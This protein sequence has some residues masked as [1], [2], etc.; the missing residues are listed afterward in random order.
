MSSNSVIA[1][2]TIFLYFRMLFVMLVTIYISRVLLNTL[3]VSDYGVYNVVAGFISLFGFLNS[4]LTASVQR[5]YNYELGKSNN[6]GVSSVYTI[7]LLSSVIISILLVIVLESFGLWYIKNIMVIPEGRLQAAVMTFHA[8]VI[9]MV[10]IVMQI[11]YVGAVLAYEKMD[12]YAIVSI[13]DVVL[14]LGVVVS[15][16]YFSCDKLILYAFSCALISVIIFFV[17][18]I[19]SKSRFSAISLQKSINKDTLSQLLSFSGWN[20]FGT[21]AFIINGQGTNLLLNFFFG[22]VVNAARA[23]SLQVSSAV[24]NFTQSI[25]MAFRPQVVESYAKGDY[26]RVSRLFYFQSKLGLLLTN[27]MIVPIILEIELILKI[28]LGPTV[29]EYTAVFTVLTLL[30]QYISVINPSIVQVAFATGYIKNFQ[31]ATSIVNI[32]LIPIAGI[33]LMLNCDPVTVFILSLVVSCVNQA[34]CM[35]QLQKVFDYNLKKY[36]LR[37]LLPCIFVLFASFVLLSSVRYICEKSIIRVF[38]IL[39]LDVILLPFFGY[40]IVLS[41]EERYY[42]LDF[43][44]NVFKHKDNNHSDNDQS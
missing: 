26:S 25:T 9:S 15:L 27:L 36:L 8:S 21:F 35:I 18:L 5:F 40:F 29:P 11:P 33:F 20:M 2:N 38:L 39:L 13:A 32:S 10:F 28:W 41:K 44:R 42:L 37:V 7:G 22:P 24:G 23:I 4:T 1:K 16:K 3:G 6:Q 12:F 14:K 34:V 30:V 31:I 43:A 17:Y 19:Y